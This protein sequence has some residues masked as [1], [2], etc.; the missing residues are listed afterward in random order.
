METSSTVRQ[1]V[2][3]PAPNDVEKYKNHPFRMKKSS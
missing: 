3:N 2:K 1:E